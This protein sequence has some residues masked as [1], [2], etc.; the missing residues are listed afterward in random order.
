MTEHRTRNHLVASPTPEPLCYHA[1]VMKVTNNLPADITDFTS[2]WHRLLH[3]HLLEEAN[4]EAETVISVPMHFYPEP[5][6]S[7]LA[8]VARPS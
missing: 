5:G 3:L 8:D 7:A 2:L 1:T 6:K 4:Q